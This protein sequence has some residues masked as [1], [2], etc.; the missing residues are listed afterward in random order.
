M[1]A[2]LCSATKGNND[3]PGNW[4]RGRSGAAMIE[5]AL[6]F[7]VILLFTFATIEFA[8]LS[9]VRHSLDTASYE[10]TRA[11][12]VPGATVGEAKTRAGEILA[13]NGLKLVDV[14]VSPSLISENTSEVTVRV[15]AELSSNS[16]SLAKFTQGVRFVAST[17][18]LTERSPS[19]IEA[20]IPTP[21]PP[22]P[23]PKPVPPVPPK[24]APPAPPAPPKP[25][26]PAPPKPAPPAP[27]KPA[28]PKPAPPKPAPPKP[29]PPKPAPP[30]P[31]PPPPPPGL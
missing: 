16:W 9:N 19:L 8:R 22:P 18:L 23:P 11:V 2:C 21:P 27:P 28:P 1:S 31:A 13:R 30:K 25:A 24:P 3:A 4:I 6:V 12:I 7:P 15:E 20:A 10:A 26:P 17:T 29:A 5:F 14:Q